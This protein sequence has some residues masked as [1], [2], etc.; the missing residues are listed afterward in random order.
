MRIRDVLNKILWT[1]PSNTADYEVT[2]VHRG[3]AMDRRTIPLNSIVMVKPSWFTYIGEGE[4]EVQIP[5]H[6]II[7]IRNIKTGRVLWRKGDLERDPMTS[8][9]PSDFE[10]GH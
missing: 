5:F 10:R 7:E 8:W 2:F 3:A 4:E 9:R 1:D 6:R